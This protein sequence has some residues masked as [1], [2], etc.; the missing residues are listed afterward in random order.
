MTELI[1]VVV[2]ESEESLSKELKKTFTKKNEF[3][4]L[5][6]TKELDDVG[7]L[8]KPGAPAVVVL[9]PGLGFRQTLD[10]CSAFHSDR[11][12]VAFLFLLEELGTEQMREAIKAG[13]HDVLGLPIDPNLLRESASEAFTRVSAL[14]S[15]LHGAPADGEAR[16]RPKAK[17]IALFST[18]GG[19]GKTFIA[20]NIA[21]AFAMRVKGKRSILLDFDLQFGDAAVMMQLFPKHT[22]HDAVA[23]I[24]KLDRD[25]MEG[26][27]IHHG[28]GAD[29]LV[30]PLEPELAEFISP[31]DL[32][33]ILKVAQ[34][35]GDLVIVDLPP[36]ITDKVLAALD[37]CDMIYIVATLDI[38]SVK[39]A[40]LALQTLGLLNY[41]Q[42]KM[43]L[44]LNRADSKVELQIHEV[45]KILG[46]KAVALIPSDREVPLSINR[47]SPLVQEFPRSE[48]AA[49]IFRLQDTVAKGIIPLK[50]SEPAASTVD[51][52]VESVHQ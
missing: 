42:E 12:E 14:A 33:T 51:K 36:I 5:S 19:V 17:T 50:P 45:E 38:P 3:I 15:K 35:I 4:L 11:P 30:S 10:F 29:V 31:E 25:M 44:I 23:N 49:S 24:E 7:D 43:S 16:R 40:K 13:A 18:K 39:N 8:L 1:P 28:S 22:V 21:A 9:G 27:F 52:E 46:I 20:V 48:V 6:A 34:Q 26:F 37:L 47:G 41:P 2:V 32:V